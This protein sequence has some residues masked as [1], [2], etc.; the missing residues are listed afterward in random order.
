MPTAA[1]G[2][3]AGTRER[4]ATCLHGSGCGSLAVAAV[5]Q[6]AAARTV[7]GA[8]AEGGG[9][10]G[11]G[12]GGTDPAGGGVGGGGGSVAAG[13]EAVEPSAETAASEAML[14]IERLQREKPSRRWRR[15]SSSATP[16]GSAKSASYHSRLQSH[17]IA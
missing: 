8:I 14:M 1:A 2:S 7:A 5:A 16:T 15:A 12:R 13:E 9:R 10:D 3:E 11:G 4:R 6:A 17:C